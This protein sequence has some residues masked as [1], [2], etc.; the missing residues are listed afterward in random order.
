[1]AHGGSA[2]APSLLEVQAA[3]DEASARL[4]EAT[5]PLERLRFE[6]V[7]APTRRPSAASRVEAALARLHE[8]DAR[9]AAVAEQLGA[10]RL[11]RPVGDGRGRPARRALAAAPSRRGTPTRPRSPSSTARLAAAEAAPDEGEPATDERDRLAE[12]RAGAPRQAEVEARL[13]VRTAE[14]RVRALAG[15]ADQLERAAASERAARER[16]AAAPGAAG[17]R[18]RGGRRR[19]RR[20]P[21]DARPR[22]RSR[23]RPRSRDAS[24]PSTART[25]R[26]GELLTAARA[27]RRELQTAL[28]PLT[29]SVHRDEIARAEQRMRI[30]A[31]EAKAL[32]ELGIEPETLLEEYGPDSSVPP[33]PV[34]PGDE[35]DPDAP[36]PSP[37]RTCAPTRRSGCGSASATL[38]LLGK[39]NPLA[40]EEFAAL[41]ERHA[42]LTEQLDDL[43]R[44]APRPARHRQGRGRAGAAGVRRGVRGHRARVRA[45]LRPAVPRR[46]GRLVLTE[47]DDLLHHRHRG[48][49]PPARQEGQAALAALRR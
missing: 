3:V 36:A 12:P 9:L 8:S 45:D 47:P 31:L 15:R 7:A 26:E 23:W 38:A 17:P 18:G 29:D 34:A 10:P 44:S 1:M 48:R 11:G 13:A 32:E 20:R 27:A 5:A 49:G 37:T 21:R 16:A 41:E 30:E 14:E 2:S 39:V 22:S 40:L 6:L 42:F 46:R 43:K 19:A 35:V 25:V 33:S 24:R 28:E 4:A